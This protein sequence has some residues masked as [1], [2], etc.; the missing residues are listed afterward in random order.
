MA[1]GSD[2]DLVRRTLERVAGEHVSVLDDPPPNVLFS[3]FGESSLDFRLMVWIGEPLA[4][5]RTASDLRFA[6]DLAFREAAIEIPFPQRDLHVRSG[7]PA[8]EG[9]LLV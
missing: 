8:S 9:P 4:A 5:P 3:E 2:T 7:P 1:Y 6:I